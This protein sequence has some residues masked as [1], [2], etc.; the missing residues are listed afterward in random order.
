MKSILMIALLF[1]AASFCNLSDKLTNKN[2]GSATP[3]TQTP[4]ASNNA[5]ES[6]ATSNNS[7]TR[8]AQTDVLPELMDVERRWKTANYKRDSATLKTI[9]A[10]EFTNV[11]ENGKTYN[12]TE[13]I[14]AWKRG[15]PTAKSWKITDER[16]ENVEGSR[17]TLIFTITVTRKNSKATRTRDTDTF[18]KR[19]GRWQVLTSQSSKM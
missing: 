13:W 12:K 3:T 5:G 7:A 4:T 17:A 11:A 1:L 18:I 15:D 14:A 10:D 19:D 8:D 9:Y 16:L 6:S 2:G